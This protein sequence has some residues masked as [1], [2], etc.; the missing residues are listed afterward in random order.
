MKMAINLHILGLWIG[1][2]LLKCGG[3]A[4]L[5]T[6]TRLEVSRIPGFC[7]SVQLE[8]LSADCRNWIPVNGSWSYPK[9]DNL[10]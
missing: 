7:G 2:K 1:Q 4:V 8:Q 6:G 3:I 5:D 10:A 9:M